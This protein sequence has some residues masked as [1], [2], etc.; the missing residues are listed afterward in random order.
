MRGAARSG[1]ITLAARSV[2]SRTIDRLRA[3]FRARTAVSCDQA[4]GTRRVRHISRRQWRVAARPARDDRA[5]AGVP[6]VSPWNPRIS[7]GTPATRAGHA[8]PVLARVSSHPNALARHRSSSR[9]TR[10]R[11]LRQPLRLTDPPM[12][13]E[14]GTLPLAK[15]ASEQHSRADCGRADEGVREPA[16][17]PP[18]T[19]RKTVSPGPS[20]SNAASSCSAGAED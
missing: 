5:R 19:T 17:V 9:P 4:C 8:N 18:I 16:K 3:G 7:C 14:S 11:G 10:V 1:A 15:H 20:W 12:K 6:H 2:T 13:R